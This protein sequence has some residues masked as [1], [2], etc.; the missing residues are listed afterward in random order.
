VASPVIA[1]IGE[2]A[3]GKSAVGLELARRFN[4]EIIA[5]DS[6]TVYRD[7]NIGTAKPSEAEQKEIR[8]HLIDIVDAPDGFNAAQ[9][10]KL[11]LTAI[12]DI[13]SRGKLPIIVGGTGL[14]V[15]GVLYDYSF[16]PPGPAELR[17]KRNG[18]TIEELL[19]EIQAEGIS[20]EGVD[21]RNKRRLIRLL[22]S[23]GQRP[24]NS[25]L[26]SNSL[27][28]GLRLDRDNLKQRV[29]Q[30]VDTMLAAGLEQE[31]KQLSEKYGWDVEPMK[32][33]GY[34][35]WREYYGGSQ[36]L[37]LTRQRIVSATMQL[38][39]RQRT[40]FKRNASIQ[41]ADDPSTV[42]DLATTFLNK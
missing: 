26:R 37:E 6:W 31:V 30:R 17:A 35:E 42:V 29:A 27:I 19:A 28:L 32:G 36:N 1:V 15:Y 38:A 18:M 25:E 5:A 2:T 7:F 22:E 23:G 8:H 3:S 24:V 11:A 21:I 33:I 39:K 12:E 34:R 14:Y 20:T 4:G 40:W 13:E 9:F 41:W 16:M 10:K